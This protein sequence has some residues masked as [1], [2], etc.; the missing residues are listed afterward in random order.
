MF[1]YILKRLLLIIPTLIIILLIN[2]FIIQA[3]P[4]GP[5]EQIIAK[6]QGHGV[7]GLE[8]VTGGQAGDGG[9]QTQTSTPAN[10]GYSK[11]NHGL[12]ADYIAK[13]EQ[14][15]GFDKPVWQRF[16]DMLMAYLRFDFGHSYFQDRQ[17]IDI[18][19][20]K[21]PVSISLGLW[22]TLVIYLVSIPLGIAKA[23]RQ[24]TKFDFWSSFV[25]VLGYAIPNFLFAILLIILFA[26]GEYFN[27]FP[28][29]GLVS[30]DWDSLSLMGK[31]LDYFWHLILPI[32]AI[33]IGGFATLTLLTR[34]S[35]LEEIGKHY[36]HTAYAKGLRP[37]QVLYGHIFRNAML[38]VIAGFP[39]TF[40]GMFFTS[41]LLIEIIFSLDGLGLLGFEA[42]INRDYPIMFA[43]LYIFTL[44]GLV[45]GILSD[46]TYIAIDPRIDFESRG[47]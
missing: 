35:F 32:T 9:G 47:Q 12:D 28:L 22:S 7:T 43:S 27:L 25:I 40:I 30:E 17:V 37:R 15:F 4:G 14:E 44:M 10:K 41:T 24:G 33:L 38:V 13:L 39:A 1:H 6:L 36:V 5:I 18:I 3:A 16:T 11:A 31:I 29:R 23:V 8:R 26:G 19:L 21:M 20:D 45:L 46:L 34:N 42:T 2:F